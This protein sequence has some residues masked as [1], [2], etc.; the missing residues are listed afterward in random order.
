MQNF[1]FPL[2]P[3]VM[4]TAS[5]KLLTLSVRSAHCFTWVLLPTYPEGSQRGEQTG[6]QA[7]RADQ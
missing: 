2:K 3:S 4:P 6:K 1:F 7:A 5:H